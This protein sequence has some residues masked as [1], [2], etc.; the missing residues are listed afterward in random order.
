M[1][2]RIGITLGDVTGIGPEVTLKT[3]A[4]WP[5]PNVRCLIIGDANRL[6]R[7]NDRL[8]LGVKLQAFESWEKPGQFFV[9]DG[10]MLPDDLPVGSPLAAEAA[11][12]FLE[13]GVAR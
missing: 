1:T 8:G 12:E 5:A 4:Q 7:L 13:E 11:L 10:A 3:L 2:G 6:Q 9:L